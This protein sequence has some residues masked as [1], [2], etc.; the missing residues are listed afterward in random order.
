MP[1][2]KLSPC[3][4]SGPVPGATGP[5]RSAGVCCRG[6]HGSSGWRRREIQSCD[7]APPRHGR[8]RRV[9]RG[10]G[11]VEE[12][13]PSPARDGGRCR[14]ASPGN[15]AIRRVRLATAG[16]TP[17][18]REPT[19][20]SVTRQRGAPTTT[21]QAPLPTSPRPPSP[22]SAGVFILCLSGTMEHTP[23]ICERWAQVLWCHAHVRREH[24]VHGWIPLL[25]TEPRKSRCARVFSGLYEL[26]RVPCSREA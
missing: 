4:V 14:D 5:R 12:S 23:I 2:T 20:F 16:R 24:V 21:S 9:P 25:V 3:V 26:R 18:G 15:A 17:L 1:S 11:A 8:V 22:T 13:A 7:A 6:R 19:G 10:S